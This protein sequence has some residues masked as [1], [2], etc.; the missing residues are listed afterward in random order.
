MFDG[1][2]TFCYWLPFDAVSESGKINLGDFID[3][4]QSSDRTDNDKRTKLKDKVIFRREEFIHTDQRKI[5]CASCFVPKRST[6]DLLSITASYARREQTR[7]DN[8]IDDFGF[9][10]FEHGI[11]TSVKGMPTGFSTEHPQ[12]GYAGY[13]YNIFILFEDSKLKFDIGRKSIHWKQANIYREYGK[14]VFNRYL[15]YV[16]KYV[17]GEIDTISDWNRDETFAEIEEIVDLEIPDIKFRKNP[18]DQEAS[19]VALFFECIGNRKITN[20]TPLCCGYRSKYDLYALWGKRKLVIEFKSKLRNIVRDFDDA[21]KMFNEINCIVCW[22]VSDEDIQALSKIG[23]TVERIVPSPI[24][25]GN[26]QI[27]PNSTH[28]LILSGFVNP[29]YVIDLKLI[30]S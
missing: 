9:A 5:R 26:S 15:Q 13:W 3:W 22:E 12:T 14:Q 16:T 1:P 7:D 21:G 29:I 8:W 27:I 11:Y 17:S 25:A 30:F 2:V 28:R 19:V 24:A 4:T 6:W 10:R 20:I 23:I 18:K